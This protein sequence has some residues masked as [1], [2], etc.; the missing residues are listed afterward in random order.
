MVL[1]Y[2]KLI[3]RHNI[4]YIEEKCSNLIL[5][6]LLQTKIIIIERLIYL[7]I[8][9]SYRTVSNGALYVVVGIKAIHIEIEE[10]GR[11]YEITKGKGIQYNREME[12]KNWIH[13]TKHVK[14]TEA[15]ENSPHYIH[16]YTDGSKNDSAVG[17][18]IATFSENNITATL[19]YRLNGRCSNNQA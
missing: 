5:F 10:A 3:F 11:Y 19:K 16:A 4:N 9:K 14:I 7:R 6:T 15:Y 17:S 12:L 1:C 8:A 2:S 13:P 18:G